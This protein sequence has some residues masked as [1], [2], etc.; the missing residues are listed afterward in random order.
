MITALERDLR[1]M[2]WP[3][4]LALGLLIAAI[5]VL[6]VQQ[7]LHHSERQDHL[8]RARDCRVCATPP[9]E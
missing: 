2:Y 3:P 4:R 5:G 9:T 6:V 7:R 8:L 1:R